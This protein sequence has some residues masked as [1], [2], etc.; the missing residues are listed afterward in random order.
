MRPLIKLCRGKGLKTII[1]LDD[2]IVSVKGKHQSREASA[3]IRDDLEKAGFIVNTE[4][5]SWVPSQIID[6][7]D[8]R[9]D[10]AEGMFSVPPENLEALKA[11]VNHIIATPKVTARQLASVIGKLFLCLWA[12]DQSHAGLYSNLN[13][14]TAWCQRLNLGSEALQELEF[15]ADQLTNFNGQSIWPRPLAVRFAYS[16]VSSS[17]YGVYLVEH[18]NLVANGQRSTEEVSQEFYMAR[19]TCCKMCVGVFPEEAPRGKNMLVY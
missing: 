12:W 15:W 17:G 10:L 16:D 3:Q 11:M 19:A 5:S 2:G 18:G 6:W 1:Y 4:K 8:F 9:I 7:L 14:R 13:Q